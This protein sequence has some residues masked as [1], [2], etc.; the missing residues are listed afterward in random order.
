MSIDDT[1]LFVTLLCILHFFTPCTYYLFHIQKQLW[2]SGLGH[3][4]SAT[5]DAWRQRRRFKVD[6]PILQAF[7]DEEGY[8]LIIGSFT[9]GIR[10]SPFWPNA[11][12]Y[13]GEFV[14]LTYCGDNGNNQIPPEFDETTQS[15]HGACLYNIFSDP[16]ETNNIASAHP[17]IVSRLSVRMVAL[18]QTIFAPNR[19]APTALSCLATQVSWGGF[20][21]PMIYD[22]AF[23]HSPSVN[24]SDV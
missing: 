15:Y 2:V 9:D 5:D 19:G 16:S 3:T 12:S 14:D 10:T 8:K 20:L 24:D 18:A 4:P 21:G 17:E 1:I 13:Y 6:Y 22:R 23:V 11:D 7:T